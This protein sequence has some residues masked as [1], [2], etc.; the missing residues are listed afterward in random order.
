MGKWLEIEIAIKRQRMG[1]S[2]KRAKKS[3]IVRSIAGGAQRWAEG[4]P[5]D[6][7]SILL[8]KGAYVICDSRIHTYLSQQ[9]G[10]ASH[11]NFTNWAAHGG[12]K[13]LVREE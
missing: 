13:L 3:L 2:W 9:F 4:Y 10:Q 5:A 11:R 12:F 6:H 8:A 1:K 7:Q